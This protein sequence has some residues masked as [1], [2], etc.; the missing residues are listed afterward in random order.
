[1]PVEDLTLIEA[2]GTRKTFEYL[3]GFGA[4]RWHKIK[5]E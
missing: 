5:V 4:S 2:L 3:C 1:M